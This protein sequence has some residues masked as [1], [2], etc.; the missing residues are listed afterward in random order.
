MVEE[1]LSSFTHR[2]RSVRWVVNRLSEFPVGFSCR[3]QSHSQHLISPLKAAFLLE[4]VSLISTNVFWYFVLKSFSQVWF[5]GELRFH[6]VSYV[7]QVQNRS[8][9][10]TNNSVR[11]PIPLSG[12]LK[13]YLQCFPVP[14]F[15]IGGIWKMTAHERNMYCLSNH[16]F[17][18]WILNRQHGAS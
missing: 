12:W 4:I 8:M 16:L 10:P 13:I 3:S 5:L 9:E 6:W 17:F 7:I 15:K 18:L 11:L 2:E 14:Y 1:N